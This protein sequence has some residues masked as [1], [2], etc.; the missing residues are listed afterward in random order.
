MTS[1][2][3][4][5]FWKYGLPVYPLISLIHQYFQTRN[6]T[7]SHAT[8]LHP[9]GGCEERE[10]AVSR[11]YRASRRERDRGW[12]GSW[13]QMKKAPRKGW[14]SGYDEN[15][16]SS[17]ETLFDFFGDLQ[18]PARSAIWSM[19]TCVLSRN[20]EMIP[21]ECNRGVFIG[22]IWTYRICMNML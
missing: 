6:Q 20:P 15:I 10:K 9:R 2:H 7:A 13:L 12:L 18:C 22:V 4:R 8:F 5:F 16:I 1:W 11:H 17:L 19:S 14:K 3:V 21:K